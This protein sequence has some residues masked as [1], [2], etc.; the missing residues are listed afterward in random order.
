MFSTDG[1]DEMSSSS[2]SSVMGWMSRWVFFPLKSWFPSSPSIALGSDDD[3][4]NLPVPNRA[5]FVARSSIPTFSSSSASSI[6]IGFDSSYPFESM[7]CY[8]RERINV[9]VC[10]IRVAG[11]IAYKTLDRY[12]SI[13]MSTG[14]LRDVDYEY[15]LVQ[16]WTGDSGGITAVIMIYISRL[17]QMITD[18]VITLFIIHNKY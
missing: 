2:S 15:V 18:F 6:K 4:D 9:C 3:G 13:A 7:M 8:V 12:R 5:R 11:Q 14:S 1:E 10:N 16:R 17:D